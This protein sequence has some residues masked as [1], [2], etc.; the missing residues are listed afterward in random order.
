[1]LARR[2]ACDFFLGDCALLDA[3]LRIDFGRSKG[4]I[5]DGRVLFRFYSHSTGRPI[6]SREQHD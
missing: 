3:A 2:S 5:Q 6:L 1:V 4:G